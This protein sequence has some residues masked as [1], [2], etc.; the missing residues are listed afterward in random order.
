MREVPPLATGELP[1]H[2]IGELGGGDVRVRVSLV[3]ERRK[4]VAVKLIQR[5]QIGFVEGFYAT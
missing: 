3:E 2:E 1:A 4:L 5:N